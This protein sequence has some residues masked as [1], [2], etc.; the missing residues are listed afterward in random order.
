MRKLRVRAG[1][2][3]L[4]VAAKLKKDGAIDYMWG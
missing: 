3:H 1:A 2:L 4:S